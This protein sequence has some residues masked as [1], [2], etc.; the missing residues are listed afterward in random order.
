MSGYS[1]DF[2]TTLKNSESTI[3]S[4]LTNSVLTEGKIYGYI[5]MDANNGLLIEFGISNKKSAP[6]ITFF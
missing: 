3:V 4:D 1:T 5:Y 2:I 6:Y